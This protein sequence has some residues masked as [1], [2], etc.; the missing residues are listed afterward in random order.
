MKNEKKTVVQWPVQVSKEW[1][2]G[3]KPDEDVWKLS[4]HEP[5]DSEHRDAFLGNGY[6][7]IRLT[8]Q[9]TGAPCDDAR[10]VVN[11]I[12]RNG[13]LIRH[14][15]WYAIDL[16][17]NGIVYQP[18]EGEHE[19]CQTLDMKR[20]V[21][22]TQD[23][24]TTARGTL[25]IQIDVFPHRTRQHLLVMAIQ[26]LSDREGKLEIV[27]SLDACCL[28][29]IS[30][31]E[32][33]QN[34]MM[35]VQFQI[36]DIDLIECIA[37]RL[38]VDT[39]A[40][41]RF[42]RSESSVIQ[43]VGISLLPNEKVHAVRYAA[44]HTCRDF[45]APQG[46]CFSEIDSARE[47][48]FD[49]LLTD[50][51]EAWAE[52]WD[53]DV[54][55]DNPRIQ[56]LIHA[57]IFQIYCHFREGYHHSI[58]PTGL[59]G[60]AWEGRVFWD[61]D[62][63]VFPPLCLLHPEL[64]RCIV[65]YRS[66]TL[67]GA[68]KDAA[69][70]GKRGAKFAWESAQT[71]EEKTPWDLATEQRHL[72]N[73]VALA[74]WQ[75]YLCSGD[76]QYLEEKASRVIAESA[77]YWLD[78]V[79]YNKEHDRYEILDVLCADEFAE[80]KN[81]NALTNYGTIL[82][83]RRAAEI[84]KRF[85]RPIPAQ[86]EQIADKMFLPFDEDKGQYLE[87]DTYQGE[88][89]K[90]ADTSILIYPYEMPMTDAV[91]ANIV[92]YYSSKIPEEHIMMSSAIYSIVSSEIGDKEKALDYFVD[93][94]SHFRPPFLLVSESPHNETLSFVTGLGGFLQTFINGFGG[95]RLHDDGLMVQPAL[96]EAIKTL[97][98]RGLHYGGQCCDL[99]IER[100]KVNV[101][102]EEKLD[103][104]VYDPAGKDCPVP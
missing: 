100:D 74:Q 8:P 29:D 15:R 101:S 1:L 84:N 45:N 12:Y 28:S 92:Y 52:L 3:A 41:S 83:L 76:E 18:S 89:I 86:W 6:Y 4:T 73:D 90:Q 40:E 63:W 46:A 96:P 71:G 65:E 70:E 47:T 78:R 7:G 2:Q 87:H 75:Y 57:A 25:E 44:L 11:G 72:Q 36:Q 43:S 58:G 35:A 23:T 21:L 19:Y 54:R 80:H 61:A 56:K 30:A 93:L 51:E 94:L 9:G 13:A 104:R 24:W 17:W 82:T 85:R 39:K 14:P 60:Y 16:K 102:S 33:H 37:C 77:N 22:T 98:I 69:K 38:D 34:E 53:S 27:D 59:S 64:G 62:L 50:H 31:L 5:N 91:K 10:T 79:S 95:I 66:K 32:I 103:F 42:E 88:T 49:V 67:E 20:C 26:V 97:E 81:N 99:C 68:M 55:V 48:G